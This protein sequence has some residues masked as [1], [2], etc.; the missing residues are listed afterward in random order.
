MK[1]VYGP[2]AFPPANLS[3]TPLALRMLDTAAERLGMS[4][5]DGFEHVVLPHVGKVRAKGR[6]EIE[7]QPRQRVCMSVSQACK[8]ALSAAARRTGRSESNVAE[9][10][11]RDFAA[12]AE[13]TAMAAGA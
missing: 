4:R 11:I 2:K 12:Q 10:V 3:L 13:P 9:Q 5:S 6:L 8:D 7:A 1:S